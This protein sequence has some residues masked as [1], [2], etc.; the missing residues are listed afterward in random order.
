MATQKF[1]EKKDSFK[2]VFSHTKVVFSS[3]KSAKKD[4]NMTILGYSCC[5]QSSLYAKNHCFTF[6]AL[7]FCPK[8]IAMFVF[9]LL[10]LSKFIYK[11]GASD[12][13]DEDINVGESV[14][15]NLAPLYY[16]N[17]YFIENLSLKTSHKNPWEVICL[18]LL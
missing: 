8:T 18:K 7:I 9:E 4:Q 14:S 6:K 3:L 2:I 16:K 1:E 10:N 5:L 17:V 12:K 15:M 13:S 11:K